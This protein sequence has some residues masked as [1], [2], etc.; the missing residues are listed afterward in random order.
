MKLPAT[1]LYMRAKERLDLSEKIGK[2]LQEAYTYIDI[3]DF[4]DTLGISTSGVE[5]GGTNSKR[6]YAKAVMARATEAQLLLVADELGLITDQQNQ[7]A[8]LPANWRGHS[9]FR[10]FISHISKD[11]LRATRLK[12]ALVLYRIDGFVAHEDIN[13]TL[14]WQEEVENALQSMDA[15]VAVHTKGFSLSNWTQQEIGYALGRGVKTISFKMDEDPTGF[16]GKH[17]AIPRRNRAAEQIAQ[18]IDNLL[19]DDPRTSVKLS[20]AKGNTTF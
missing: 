15:L 16:I 1:D 7:P 8:H 4:F 20:D 11:K 14:A 9:N 12:E 3:N 5:T 18:E 19:A 2:T 13:P 17:Q 10:L 6:I